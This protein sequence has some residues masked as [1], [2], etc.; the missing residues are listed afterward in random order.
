MEDKCSTKYP[1]LLVHGIGFRD[2]K[3]IGYW[4]RIPKALEDEG[5]VIYYGNQ[6]SW[7]TIE[8]NAQILKRN[9]E[10]ILENTKCGK[11]NV[12][13]HS[14]GG[15]EM[16]YVIS[17]LEKHECIASLTT[18]ATPHHGVKT[19]DL[20]CKFPHALFKSIAVFLNAWSKLLGD[21]NPDFYNACIKFSTQNIALFNEQNPNSDMVYYQSYAAVMK[22]S[23][24]DMIMFWTHLIIYL[25]EGENDG[26]ISLSSTEWGNFKGVFRGVTMRGVSHPDAVD[27][28]RRNFTRKKAEGKVSD[29]RDV[30]VEIV[31]ELKNL[32]F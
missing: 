12:I 32:G 27:L 11:L 30:Y 22:N 2:N 23:F 31:S 9:I 16:R 14:K 13:A 21:E 5:A 3:H 10:L 17:T 29:I 1:I 7:G 15:L 18:I 24:S 19:M 4:G 28:R 20:I 26:I 6:D 25:F 8:H